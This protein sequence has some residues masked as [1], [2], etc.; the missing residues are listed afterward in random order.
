MNHLAADL[1]WLMTRGEAALDKHLRLPFR[2]LPTET[3]N[4]YSRVRVTKNVPVLMRDNVR[5]YADV[6]Q[7]ERTN[8]G[9]LPTVLIRMPYGKS[10]AYCSM[11]AHGKY[12]ARK[13]YV[14]VVQDVRG[15]F[16]SKGE[17]EPFVDEARDGYDTVDWVS[18]QPWCNGSVGMA[19]ESY[20]ATTA[21]AAASSHHPSLKCI[22]PG[23]QGLDEY[24]NVYEGGAFCLSSEGLW[25]ADSVGRRFLNTH[26]I[27]TRHL[28]L[29][30]LAEVA[31][32]PTELYAGAI[33]NP[34]RTSFW[35]ALDLSA[36]CTTLDTPVLHWGGWYDVLL[37]GVL[38]NWRDVHDRCV[39]ADARANQWLAI[40]PIDHESTPER[41]GRVGRLTVERH[42]YTYDRVQEFFDYWLRGSENGFGNSKRVRLFVVGA[43]RWREG[44]EFPLRGTRFVKYFLHSRGNATTLRGD[45]A[46]S[47][48]PPDEESED[49]FVYDPARP[50]DYWVGKSTWEIAACM[51]D[52]RPT[53]DRPDV[54]VY[55][56]QPL[57][58]DLEVVGPLAVTLYASS[59]A[60][61]TDFTAALVDVW[62]DGYS[63]LVQEGIRRARYRRSNTA[64]SLIEPGTINELLIDLS[65][66]GYLFS[67]GHRLRVEISSS[68]F[69]RYDSNPNTGHA[70]GLDVELKP[71]RQCVYHDSQ[72]PS[73]ITLP[74]APS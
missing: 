72:R 50:V 11:A 14:C 15:K 74:L 33:R 19:G 49:G 5:L 66:I 1:K 48:E 58:T 26:R 18:R 37:R 13:G 41:T 9:R 17:F 16:R 51:E 2:E 36:S 69:D 60:A 21:W 29:V 61:D 4:V 43:N 28:P 63:Q 73:H 46:L 8:W 10:E 25:L 67:A 52:R 31:G 64:P 39:N 40:G 6:Y 20:Y 35:E 42:G 27:D 7:P 12:W 55:T 68:N 65:A 57:T 70:F 38:H 22:A 34:A 47:P 24:D 23:N 44:D 71:A 53:E 54:L 3:P 62:P 56:S 30:S 32:L 45:G 59:S